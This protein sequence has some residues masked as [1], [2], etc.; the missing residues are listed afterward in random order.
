MEWNGRKCSRSVLLLLLLL[1]YTSDEM[2]WWA[3]EAATT[4]DVNANSML[5]MA[6]AVHLFSESKSSLVL[7]SCT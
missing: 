7:C 6:V 1:M 3:V 5:E 4:R 2:S